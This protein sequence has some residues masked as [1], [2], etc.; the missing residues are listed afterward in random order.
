MALPLGFSGLESHATNGAAGTEAADASDSAPKRQRMNGAQEECDAADLLRDLS[1]VIPTTVDAVGGDGASHDGA[2]D[3]EVENA[4]PPASAVM[5][6]TTARKPARRT[7]PAP[8]GCGAVS[9]EDEELQGGVAAGYPA[10]DFRGSDGG[11]TVYCV[12][13]ATRERHLRELDHVGSSSGHSSDSGVSVPRHRLAYRGGGTFVAPGDG[14]PLEYYRHLF[15]RTELAQALLTVEGGYFVAANAQFHALFGL[16]DVAAHEACILHLVTPDE[17][18][19]ATV[20]LNSVI[21]A[22]LPDDATRSVVVVLTCLVATGEARR[23]PMVVTWVPGCGTCDDA[24]HLVVLPA[25]EDPQHVS[26]PERIKV[27]APARVVGGITG[28]PGASASSSAARGPAPQYGTAARGKVSSK[29]VPAASRAAAAPSTSGGAK[30][31]TPG[32]GHNHGDVTHGNGTSSAARAGASGS[33]AGA[34]AATPAPVCYRC[35]Y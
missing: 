29:G 13:P 23:V 20:A 4:V 12:E 3:T 7:A 2:V 5:L 32:H 21:N 8:A 22:A 35:S 34:L 19:A 1:P 9:E 24:L 27:Q 18:R 26:A 31:G 11:D 16:A 17:M 6:T 30:H 10:G 33:G 15:G 14:V 25:P 28:A